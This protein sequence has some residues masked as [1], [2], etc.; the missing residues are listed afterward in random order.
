[1]KVVFERTD[2][3]QY[4]IHAIRPGFPDAT[5]DPAPGFD[6]FLPH[7]V[8]HLVAEASLGL[9]GGVFGQ[10]ANGGLAGTFRIRPDEALSKRKMTR[11]RRRA[12]SRDEKL[13]KKGLRDS[14]KSERATYLC[15]YEWLKR[16]DNAS[17]RETAREMA[18]NAAHIK[19]TAPAAEI[20]AL[21]EEML[22]KVCSR[23]DSLSACWAGTGVGEHMS[24]S[25]PDVTILDS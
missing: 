5:M 19:A 3:K 6:P 10:L 9:K 13:L 25:W 21:D 2:K 8:M 20:E 18:D 17:Q 24:I 11:L 4:A 1:M 16:S 15:W 23:L 22:T 12:D 7:D 14:E